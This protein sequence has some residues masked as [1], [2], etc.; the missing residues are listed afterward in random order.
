MQ[1]VFREAKFCFVPSDD[2]ISHSPIVAELFCRLMES[3]ISVEVAKKGAVARERWEEWLAIDESRE[4]WNVA[5]SRAREVDDWALWSDA[6]RREY[7]KN[8]L[9]P[10]TFTEDVLH[11]FILAVSFPVD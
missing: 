4:E 5:I 2:E 8:L 1:R 11:R 6:K 7:I 10:F 9:S 3:L